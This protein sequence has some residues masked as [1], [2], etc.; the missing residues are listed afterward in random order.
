MFPYRPVKRHSIPIPRS[1]SALTNER[2]G[3][4]I[5]NK[6][7]NNETKKQGSFV[8]AQETKTEINTR[9]SYPDAC[10]YFSGHK[11]FSIRDQGSRGG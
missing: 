5:V 2:A 8:F 6:F 1:R 4:I 9:Y 3:E 7:I 10:P 11:S